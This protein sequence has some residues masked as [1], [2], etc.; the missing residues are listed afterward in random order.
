MVNASNRGGRVPE[1]P[2]RKGVTAENMWAYRQNSET[3]REAEEFDREDDS[4]NL[5]LGHQFGS[6]QARVTLVLSKTPVE[7]VTHRQ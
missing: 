7:L 3:I 4:Y 2:P 5:Y 1:S 6:R